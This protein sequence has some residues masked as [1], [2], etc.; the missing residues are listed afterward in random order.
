MGITSREYYDRYIKTPEEDICGCGNKKSFNNFTHGYN[1]YCQAHCPIASAIRNDKVSN[2]FKCEDGEEKLK[3]CKE[4]TKNTISSDP[5]H[6]EKAAGKR[7]ITFREKCENLGIT[8]EE[9]YTARAKHATDVVKNSGRTEEVVRKAM[10]TKA[11]RNS[12]GG[13]SG[14]K[15][16]LLGESIISVQ[17]YEPFVLDYLQEVL[18]TKKIHAGKSIGFFKYFCE[19]REEIHNYF[20]D[21]RIFEHIFI[22]VKSEYTFSMHREETF[23]KLGSV[24]MENKVAVLVIPNKSESRKRK[25]DGSKKLIDWAI[26][27]QASNLDGCIIKYEEG[28]T[29]I[30]CGVESSDSKCRG[31]LR[32]IREQ[33]IVWSSV[34]IEAV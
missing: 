4:R 28:S 32:Q 34:K 5:F 17:G 12:F 9:Y 16:Y 19:M 31:S 20:P 24:L 22:E 3:L 29:T 1:L 26:S 14:Y 18:E 27:S 6:Y 33:D 10:D 23:A 21:I 11:K 25:L 13:K 2:R 15:P 8:E 30:L 7:R